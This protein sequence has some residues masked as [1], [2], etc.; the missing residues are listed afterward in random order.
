MNL[1][2][3]HFFF[4]TFTREVTCVISFLILRFTYY[5]RTFA[6]CKHQNAGRSTLANIY[7]KFLLPV[8][9]FDGFPRFETRERNFDLESGF[10]K[11]F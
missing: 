7:W 5:Y 8:L 11:P 4:L 3:F 6:I 9:N 1:K 2:F 10:N